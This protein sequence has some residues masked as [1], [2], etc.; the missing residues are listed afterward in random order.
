[1]RPTYTMVDLFETPGRARVLRALSQLTAPLSI[2][3]IG[4][5]AGLSHA[6]A[7]AILRDL[8]AMGIVVGT[9]V[10]R[11]I[12]YSVRT[13]NA[14]YR[15]MVRPLLDAEERI[16]TE[17]QADLVAAFG[18]DSLSL[19]LYG[20]YATGTQD[21]SSDIDVFALAEN[22]RHKQAL[23]ETERRIAHDFAATY[24]SPLSLLAYTLREAR[25]HLPTGKS[26][27]RTELESTG[28]ILHGLG[29]SEWEIDGEEAADAVGQP[30]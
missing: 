17:L 2:R 11:A 27:F 16:V 19:I 30:G 5:A 26:G 20:S 21:E 6:A 8:A 9:P 13:S 24:G 14:Y 15:H 22:E 29:V 25:T 23:Y 7:G 1:M 10:G 4:A 3:G 18:T 12:V 28:I